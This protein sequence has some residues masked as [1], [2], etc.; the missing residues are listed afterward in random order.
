MPIDPRRSITTAAAPPNLAFLAPSRTAHHG[1]G[2]PSSPHAPPPPPPR[3][4]SDSGHP[5]FSISVNA[6]TLSLGR[7]A[8]KRQVLRGVDL[9]VQRGSLHMLLGPNGCGKSTLLR[10]LGGLLP[11]DGGS[12]EADG[13]S[14][15]VFQNPDHQVVMPTVAA[16]VAFGLGRYKIPEAQVAAAVERAL[17]LVNMSE[18]THRATHTLS[19]G[20]RQRVA[21]AG[22]D[23]VSSFFWGGGRVVAVLGCCCVVGAIRVER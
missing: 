13:P 19:G 8:Q 1:R 17:S 11:L 3:A 23:R 18:F 5:T 4:S 10:V 6:A 20:Q 9:Q 21:I 16:D 15:F 14:G 22:E 12:V 2:A 7:A